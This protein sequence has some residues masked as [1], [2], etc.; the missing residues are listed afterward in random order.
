MRAGMTVTMLAATACTLLL[1][2]EATM[3]R[4]PRAS[5][6]V[7]ASA[8]P[9]SEAAATFQEAR[10][11]DTAGEHETAAA[12][13]ARVVAL[14][15]DHATAYFNRALVRMKQKRADEAREDMARYIALRPRHADGY[16]ARAWIENEIGLHHAARADAD[17]AL[18]IDGRLA[19]AYADRAR[20]AYAMGQYGVALADAEA[21]QA[22]APDDCHAALVARIRRAIER[23]NCDPLVASLPTRVADL[24]RAI[25]TR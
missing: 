3:V 9:A 22:L 15:P 25:D 8:A 18:A 13:Y 16:R 2:A 14:E 17:A 21:A 20:A 19:V 23:G 5:I 12:A 24:A 1:A 6:P 10:R 7:S 4:R 11:L